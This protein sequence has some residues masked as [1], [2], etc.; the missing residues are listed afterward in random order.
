MNEI[1]N[2]EGTNS[3]ILSICERYATLR[4]GFFSRRSVVCLVD[5]LLKTI[6]VEA[7]NPL[8]HW[9]ETADLHGGAVPRLVW[10]PVDHLH[11]PGG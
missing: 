3:E 6:H 1:Q 11:R 9:H 5:T 8:R 4:L 10:R 2:P 7:A